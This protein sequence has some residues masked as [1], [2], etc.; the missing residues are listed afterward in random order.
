M[1]Q[2]GRIGRRRG[3]VIALSGVDGAGKSF[4][5]K[6]LQGSLEA[7]GLR[8]RIEW[9]PIATNP[10]LDRLVAPLQWALGR[11]RGLRTPRRN[12]LG[13]RGLE[14]NPGSVLRQRSRTANYGWATL[15]AAANG[16]SH[17]FWARRHRSAGWIVVFDRYVLDSVVRARFLYGNGRPLSLP[18]TLIRLL[19]PRPDL[20]FFLD[21]PAAA[22]VARKEDVWTTE[23]LERQVEL[24]RQEFERC[25]VARLDGELPSEELAHEILETTWRRLR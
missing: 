25:G 21:V 11:F 17:A 10:W 18:R 14:P 2:V 1:A 19:S 15:V 12:Q 6:A 4:Q 24:Y 20:A 13:R 5:A 8:A 23:E 3:L 7:L 9:I 16:V 22:S